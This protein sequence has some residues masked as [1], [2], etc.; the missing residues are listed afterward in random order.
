MTTGEMRMTTSG[1][2]YFAATI[3]IVVG[4]LDA[5]YGL[6]AIFN[7]DWVVFT[8]SSVVLLDLTAWGWIMLITGIIAILVGFGALYGQTWARVVG[9]IVA[10][11]N[12]IGVT[13]ILSVYPGWG[14]LIIG[15]NVLV[16]YALAVHGDEV[17]EA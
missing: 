9:I 4:I 1:W 2:V 7:S 10:A 17:A 16:I 11:L 5:F 6:V 12:L 3:F 8:S 15:L 14:F 13:V